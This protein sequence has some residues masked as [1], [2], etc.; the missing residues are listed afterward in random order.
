MENQRASRDE[1]F[2]L[3]NTLEGCSPDKVWDSILSVEKIKN[4]AT[5]AEL[6]GFI[7]YAI[8]NNWFLSKNFKSDN[9]EDKKGIFIILDALSVDYNHIDSEGNNF[10]HYTVNSLN[11]NK[12]E[13]SFSVVFY[14]E[15]ISY[16]AYNFS[17]KNC[18]I[19][20][21]G[22]EHVINKTKDIGLKNKKGESILFGLTSNLDDLWGLKWWIKRFPELDIN[23]I[24]NDGVGLLGYSLSSTNIKTFEYL[25]QNGVSCVD[26]KNYFK[27]DIIISI[28]EMEFN[29]K[30]K[31]IFK[32]IIKANDVF[33][34]ESG[35]IKT[36][37]F[38]DEGVSWIIYEKTMARYKSRARDWISFY[39]ENFIS[40]DVKLNTQSKEMLKE[41]VFKLIDSNNITDDKLIQ[42]LIGLKSVILKD[43]LEK[44]IQVKSISTKKSKI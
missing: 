33:V 37:N 23:C 27:D 11:R 13:K 38:F 42:S 41:K 31:E 4:T 18:F 28:L 21:D 39:C 40:K 22:V 26:A 14:R 43:D 36:K 20:Q 7:F 24:N 6:L 44:N 3:M 32:E 19:T 29:K 30:H 2:Q 1:I 5:W 15:H 9:N 35:E 12:I 16:Y 8:E 10:L 25:L 34:T 17:K